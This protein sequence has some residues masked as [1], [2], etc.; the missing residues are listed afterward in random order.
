MIILIASLSTGLLIGGRYRVNFLILASFLLVCVWISAAF[1]REE[2]SAI[3]VLLLF[4]YLS[5]LQGGFLIGA[6]IQTERE[7]KRKPSIERE[8]SFNEGG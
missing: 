5:A 6:Y 8:P 7:E 2:F 1:M 4:S 3:D